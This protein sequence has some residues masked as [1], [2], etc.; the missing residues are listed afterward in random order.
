MY[1]FSRS[2]RSE[3]RLNGSRPTNSS[4]RELA[5]N[6]PRKGS[7]F[8]AARLH[9]S[10][11]HSLNFACVAD[12]LNLLYRVNGLDEYV[13]QLQRRLTQLHYTL[14]Q[15]WTRNAERGQNWTTLFVRNRR[16]YTISSVQ[17]IDQKKATIR[18]SSF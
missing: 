16:D 3:F 12:T 6:P 7:I 14:V 4:S 13:G 1:Q 17:N 15:F 5:R 10:K 11:F 2:D 9:V 18:S 8:R